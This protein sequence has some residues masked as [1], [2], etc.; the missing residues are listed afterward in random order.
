MLPIIVANK[1][2]MKLIPK[3]NWLESKK[4]IRKIEEN[5]TET[6]NQ[7]TDDQ[8]IPEMGFPIKHNTKI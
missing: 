2:K 7:V 1:Q 4:A 6:S 8:L 3:N 5:Q